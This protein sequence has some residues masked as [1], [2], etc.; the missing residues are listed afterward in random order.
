MYREG[1]FGKKRKM[2]REKEKGEERGGEGDGKRQR[3]ALFR[4][5][6]VIFSFIKNTTFQVNQI[7]YR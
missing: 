3:R 6:T 5:T 4:G 7:Y 2:R 1:E